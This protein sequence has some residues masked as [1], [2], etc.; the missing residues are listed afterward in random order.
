VVRDYAAR[1]SSHASLARWL[2]RTSR[3]GGERG[4]KSREKERGKFKSEGEE[5]TVRFIPSPPRLLLFNQ[6]LFLFSRVGPNVFG[7]GLLRESLERVL[8]GGNG[9]HR[10]RERR[11]R[12]HV[13]WRGRKQLLERERGVQSFPLRERVNVQCEREQRR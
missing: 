5:R 7:E 3:F 9:D 4:N 1:A 10:L 13:L 12:H 2:A 6:L 11:R 8:T